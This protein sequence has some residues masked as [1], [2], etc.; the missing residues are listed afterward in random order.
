MK[1]KRPQK[2][3]WIYPNKGSM[4]LSNKNIFW[5]TFEEYETWIKDTFHKI[6]HKKILKDSFRYDRVG[7]G[8]PQ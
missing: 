1:K 5:G 6:W 7:K 3:I 4:N 2:Y 8:N